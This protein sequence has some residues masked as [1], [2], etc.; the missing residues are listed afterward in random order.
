MSQRT[1]EYDYMITIVYLDIFGILVVYTAN[2][3]LMC[4]VVYRLFK[5]EKRH[6]LRIENTIK[7]QTIHLSS[8]LAIFPWQLALFF[9][10]L[11]IPWNNHVLNPCKISHQASMKHS[12]PTPSKKRSGKIRFGKSFGG[13]MSIISSQQTLFGEKTTHRK[14]QQGSLF[15]HPTNLGNV[16]FHHHSVVLQIPREVRCWGIPKPT[17]KKTWLQKGLEDK[18]GF[19]V[20]THHIVVAPRPKPCKTQ[21][22]RLC[23]NHRAVNGKTA[24]DC[25]P[26]WSFRLEKNDVFWSI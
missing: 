4:Y 18:K 19:I 20:F 3:V 11:E 7:T 10:R 24:V 5:T 8:L 2:W 16:Q 1:H 15:S 13:G 22:L 25:W 26:T 23:W 9:I 6:W 17:Q 21:R 14:H 12:T